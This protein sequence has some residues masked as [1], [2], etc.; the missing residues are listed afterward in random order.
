MIAVN[1]YFSFTPWRVFFFHPPLEF[2]EFQICSK[3][4]LLVQC[5][6]VSLIRLVGGRKRKCPE[7]L[8]RSSF[9]TNS[10][11][12]LFFLFIEHYGQ[13]ET[14]IELSFIY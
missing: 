11:Q 12:L 3:V 13:Q 10:G 4:I 1:S 8:R 6:W 14:T 2:S 5:G 9:G 7:L